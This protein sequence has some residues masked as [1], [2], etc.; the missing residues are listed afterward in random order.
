MRK[1]PLII[2]LVAAA[3]IAAV[4]FLYKIPMLKQVT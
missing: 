2:A 3:V 1:K 4:I